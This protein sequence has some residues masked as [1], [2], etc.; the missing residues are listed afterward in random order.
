MYHYSLYKDEYTDTPIGVVQ[1]KQSNTIDEA[2]N[3]ALDDLSSRY[4]ESWPVHVRIY[5]SE[6]S[7][8]V[9]SKFVWE[10]D[11]TQHAHKRIDWANR[12]ELGEIIE[13]AHADSRV[14]K[15]QYEK[16]LLTP[17]DFAKEKA[18]IWTRAWY[19]IESKG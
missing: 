12:P 11:M 18:S 5:D 8:V 2:V 4:V 3:A 7:Y 9:E 6:E 14:K 16:G 10:N 15:E 17:L 1:F 19:D 13:K